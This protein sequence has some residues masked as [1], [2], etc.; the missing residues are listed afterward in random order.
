MCVC[1]CVCDHSIC[2]YCVCVRVWFLQNIRFR[3]SFIFPPLP[4]HPSPPFLSG[5]T[6]VGATSAL[7]QTNSQWS[8]SPPWCKFSA[9]TGILAWI[10]PES[11]ISPAAGPVQ[12]WSDVSGNG[13]NFVQN[14]ASQQPT[15]VTSGINGLRSLRFTA[16]NQQTILLNRNFPAP[17]SVFIVAKLVGGTSGRILSGINNNWLLGWWNGAQDQGYFE[18]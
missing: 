5:Y 4:F 3:F 10:A 17:V 2:V 6:L 8:A 13:N 9:V 7:C 15:L 12:T 11:A 16:A 1:V 18:V 14:T